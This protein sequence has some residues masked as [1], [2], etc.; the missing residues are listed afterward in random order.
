MNP[1][2]HFL[3]ISTAHLAPADRLCL[4]TSA[5]AGT[6]GELCCG[7]MPHGWFVHADEE[8]PAIPDTLWALMVEARGRGCDYLLFDADGP[9]LPGFPCFDW[10]APA[11]SSPANPV[12]LGSVP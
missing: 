7:A 6:R 4:E 3:D 2:R 10:E 11:P 9:I 12:V 8:H 5:L 1:V